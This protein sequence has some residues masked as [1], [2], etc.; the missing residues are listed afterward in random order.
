MRGPAIS[1]GNLVVATPFHKN[2]KRSSDAPTNTRMM[3]G[4][5]SSRS[6]EGVKEVGGRE[7]S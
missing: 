4:T 7:K 1:S 3:T 5:S 6:L 2:Y